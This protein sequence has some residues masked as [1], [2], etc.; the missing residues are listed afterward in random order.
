MTKKILISLAV[1]CL[2]TSCKDADNNTGKISTENNNTV[3]SVEVY[4]Q[5]YCEIFVVKGNVTDLE[6]AVY[7]TL[8]CNDCPQEVWSV[9]DPEKLT[10]ELDAKKI[11]MN[12][13]RVFLMNKIG[14]FN[15]PP[16]K[17]N[18][19]G[20]EMVKR[21]VLPLKIKTLLAGESEPYVENKVNRQTQY[22][23]NKGTEVYLLI[24]GDSYYIMQSF[25]MITDP[26]LKIEDLKT[27][28]SKI[29]LPSGWKYEVK[30]LDEE[31]VLETKEGGEA[32]VI[33]DD[34]KNTY[35][36]INNGKL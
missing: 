8:G 19:G 21:A 3:A 20:L 18:I 26:D 29:K 28:N 30:V 22:I 1:C 36:K 35:Q 4:G 31:F 17:V 14:Q 12:G 5:R 11:I 32:F 33:Q 27:L 10:K 25:A 6:A 7:N 9:I 34:L 23:F 16:P 2:F 15:E 13:P 24:N